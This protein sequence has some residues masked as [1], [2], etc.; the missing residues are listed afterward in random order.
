MVQGLVTDMTNL[1][2]I[3]LCSPP[4]PY[5]LVHNAHDGCKVAVPFEPTPDTL[6]AFK[7]AVE[8]EWAIDGET[9]TST[10]SWYMV[11]DDGTKVAVS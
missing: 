6:R 11:K 4:S 2:I 10:A 1:A 7:G 5:I 3:D 8:K 9:I